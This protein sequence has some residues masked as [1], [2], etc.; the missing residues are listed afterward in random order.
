M[1]T[2][3][4]VMLLLSGMF[5]V[6]GLGLISLFTLGIF[7]NFNQF[8]ITIGMVAIPLIPFLLWLYMLY[9]FHTRKD[10]RKFYIA[11]VCIALLIFALIYDIQMAQRYIS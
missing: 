4:L 11:M 6:Y 2:W 3:N 5:L 10:H 1:K 7:S 8:V 9:R